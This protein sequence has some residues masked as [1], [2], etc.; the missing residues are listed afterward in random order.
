MAGAFQSTAFQNSAFQVD[1]ARRSVIST[2]K[3]FQQDEIERRKREQQAE[4]DARARQLADAALA[5]LPKNRPLSRWQRQ[6]AMAEG[7]RQAAQEAAHARALQDMDDE[8][9]FLLLAA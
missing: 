2:G 5:K 6:M 9:T 4:I 1:T 7:A 3:Y 8:E